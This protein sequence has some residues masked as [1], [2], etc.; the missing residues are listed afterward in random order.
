MKTL[1]QFMNLFRRPKLDSDMAEEMRL[2][3]E[4]QTELNRKAG[5]TPDEARYAALRQF[6]NLAGI[7]EQAREGSGW[8]WLEQG[9]RDLCYALR[10]LR[11]S[12][13]FTVAVVLTLALGIG[14]NTTVFS[15]VDA[16][17]LRPKPVRE[18]SEVWSVGFRDPQWGAT[19]QNISFPYYC[20]YRNGTTAFSD[21]FGYASVSVPLREGGERT[22]FFGYLV[23]GNYFSGLGVAP[24]L[25]RLLGPTDDES[26]AHATVAVI[27]Y[28]YWQ[29]RWAG[30]ADVLGKTLVVNETSL[31][32]VGVASAGFQGL[33]DW[34]GVRRQFWA[35]ASLE[36]VLK[37]HATYRM[38]GRLV[39]GTSPEQAI[40]N[41]DAA[42]L[43][44]SEEFKKAP[45][46]YERYGTIPAK[47]RAYLFKSALG[48][49]G[50]QF[51]GRE[52]VA[53]LATLFLVAVGLVLLIAC[54]NAANLLL[55]RALRRR[56]EIAVRLMLGATRG[57]LTRQLLIESL[58]LSLLGATVGLLLS[59]WGINA[60]LAMQSGV[61]KYLPVEGIRLDVRALAFTLGLSGLTGLVFGLVPAWQ[62]FR[63]EP[64]SGLKIE[65][66]GAP[67][68]RHGRFTLQNLLVVG[69]VAACVVLLLCAGLC[70]R[71]FGKLAGVDAGFEARNVMVAS[72][73]LKQE[74]HSKE[75][76][77]AFMDQLTARLGPMPGV[78]ACAVSD[79]MLPLSGQYARGGI[80]T[81]EG[82]TPRPGERI[83][84]AMSDV[85][86]GYFR[87]LGIPVVA[88]R[89][90]EPRDLAGESG[91][92]AVVNESFV[93]RYWPHQNPLGKHLNK[94]EVVGVVRD[95]RMQQLNKEPEPQVFFGMLQGG[96]VDMGSLDRSFN[97]LIRLEKPQAAFADQ[98]RRELT[99]MDASVKLVDVVGLDR[100]RADS[101]A[102]QRA[103]MR[104][105]TVLGGGAVVLA[106][107]GLYGVLAYAVT[108]RTREI[109][110]RIAIGAQP[111]DVQWLTVRQGMGV[112]GVGLV[113]GLLLA[114]WAARGLASLLYG[115]SP[116]DIGTFL[117]VSLLFA[118]VAALACWLP[119]RRA[120]KVDPVVALR[121][122]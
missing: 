13:G 33:N 87:V 45:V 30:S 6:G 98:L 122:E 23:T 108:Q 41:L 1:K 63:V 17:L 69:Q 96:L 34:G 46:G 42:T 76:T 88:G 97:V 31:T 80:E 43:R 16:L 27:S 101:L 77:L 2:H 9:W 26:C 95:I 61:L 75:A 71:S 90:F 68:W 73:I 5:M 91:R 115:I 79:N 99:A 74:K 37:V 84:Y 32:I 67:A 94:A 11:R 83:T 60:L 56:R 105:L 114:V 44:L 64:A 28:D 50:M 29:S 21:F 3:V 92:V 40:A 24:A 93:R 52:Q 8:V 119:A 104:I 39:P 89:D 38:A 82:Y 116:T 54:G 55:A 70:V 22:P 47:L 53:R 20:A 10:Q 49:I 59:H 4:L 66:A 118:T 121:A 7:Q 78:M 109:G 85:G 14:V 113:L 107:I 102:A 72:L 48:S 106:V 120:A 15:I 112:F 111:R 51:G 62:L 18:A 12:P 81:L 110:V 65:A 103:L 58:L 25:G 19:Y 117:G 35:P 86:P 36:K 100:I 57:R